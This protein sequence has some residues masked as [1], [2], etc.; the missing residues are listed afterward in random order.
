MRRSAPRSSKP[1]LLRDSRATWSRRRPRGRRPCGSPLTHI[2]C[3]AHAAAWWSAA[4]D[5]F[6]YN[7]GWRGEDPKAYGVGTTITMYDFHR[8]HTFRAYEVYKEESRRMKLVCGNKDA[9]VT[10]SLLSVNEWTTLRKT[11]AG[12][13]QPQ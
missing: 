8:T 4:D 10:S 11:D 9:K 7:W 13:R 12:R 1:H 2:R 3:H 6:N 5:H